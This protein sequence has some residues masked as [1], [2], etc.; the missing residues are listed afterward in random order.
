M[1]GIFNGD[2]PSHY[3]DSFDLLK[4]YIDQSLDQH[5]E[6]LQSILFPIFVCLFLN[7][8]IKKY[9]KEA[10]SFLEDQ[11][12]IFTPVHTEILNDLQQADDIS[13]LENPQISGYLKN[14]FVVKMSLYSFQMLIHFVKLNQLILIM[15]IL[16]QNIDFQ[17]SS[18]KNIV[19]QKC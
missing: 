3:T 17:L 18:E 13:K 10:Q 4:K 14:K 5:K 6:D 1:Q 19:D 8:I 9:Y 15:H 12:P 11:R 2:S 7:M 16:N